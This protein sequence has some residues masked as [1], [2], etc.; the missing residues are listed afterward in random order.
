VSS[1]RRLDPRQVTAYE[2]D[3]VLA[4][5]AVLEAHEVSHFASELGRLRSALGGARKRLDQC[6]LYFA[7]A[8]ALATHPVVLDAVEDLLGPDVLVHSSRVFY[9]PPRDP[10]FVS[11]HQDG[12]Y[13]GLNDHPVTTAWIAL[14]ESAPESGC[15]R[16]LP[17]SHRRG[18]Y[19]HA[20]HVSTDNLVNHGQEV[21]LEISAVEVRDVPLR[22]GEMSLHHINTVHGSRPNGS[23]WE[24]VG[25]SVSYATPLVPR[26][27]GAIVRARGLD[28]SAR[29]AV[30]SEPPPSTLTA[31]LPAYQ[32]FL[33]QRASA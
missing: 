3:G 23:G 15:L 2:E 13:S 17:G 28:P 25:F 11:W 19:P 6:H 5:V 26:P 29:F 22:P 21:E 30:L 27:A 18:V 7:W 12:R 24:R 14:S 10:A 4:P 20:E 33:A 9:K 8:Y 32:R 16:V 31:A 1:L